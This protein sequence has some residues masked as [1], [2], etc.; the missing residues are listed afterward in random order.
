MHQACTGSSPTRSQHWEKEV[1]TGSHPQLGHY[2]QLAP[3]GKAEISFL[4]WSLNGHIN[5][6][7][8]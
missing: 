7:L 6:I 5:H 4:Q 2:L 8:G 3:T 1:D